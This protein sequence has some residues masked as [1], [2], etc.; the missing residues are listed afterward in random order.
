MRLPDTEER[1]ERGQQPGKDP[2]NQAIRCKQ[3]QR[4]GRTAQES[5][6]GPKRGAG[7]LFSADQE[8]QRQQKKADGIRN[9]VD[10]I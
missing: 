3:G 6:Q 10:G 2:I 1:S 9:D 7:P 8:Q 5:R 4:R